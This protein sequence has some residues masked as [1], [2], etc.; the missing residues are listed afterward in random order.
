[1]T[2]V[3]VGQHVVYTDAAGVDQDALVTDILSDR[4]LN[5][6]IVSR[7][8]RRR[9]PCGRQIER[10]AGVPHAS[11]PWLGHGPFWRRADEPKPEQPEPQEA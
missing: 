7:N 3:T 8:E 10:P 4:Y 5:L 6:V 2:K 1:M 11:C 9:D